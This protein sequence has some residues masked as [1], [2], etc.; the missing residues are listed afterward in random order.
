MFVYTVES[1]LDFPLIIHKPNF[2]LINTNTKMS[3]IHIK[4][5]FLNLEE[6]LPLLFAFL[7]T[8]LLKDTSLFIKDKKVTGR[9]LDTKPERIRRKIQERIYQL[10][11]EDR[12][13]ENVFNK[14]SP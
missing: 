7:E 10:G 8:P 5:S 13:I 9:D 12:Q 1:D 3:Y 11:S 4:L 2:I 14:I 6:C